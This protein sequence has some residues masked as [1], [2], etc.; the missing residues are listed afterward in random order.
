MADF[1]AQNHWLVDRGDG[2]PSVNL[3]VLSFVNPLKLLNLTTDAGNTQGI[4]NGMTADVVNYFKSRNI[5]VMLAVGGITYT[6]D[7][8]T[9]LGNPAQLATNAAQ[10]AASLGVGI[11]ID[12]EENTTPNLDAL[13]T[14]ISTYR[15]RQPYDASGA[16]PAARL[17]IDLGAGDRYLIGIA[18]RATSDWLNPANPVLDYANAMVPNRQPSGASDAIT[19]WQEHVDGKP[20]YSPPIGPLAPAKFTGA[21]YLETGRKAI[22]ECN[23]F[24]G[25]LESST[26]SYVQTVAPNGAGVTAGM[27]GY[28]FW[29]SECPSTTRVCTTPPNACQGGV[30]AGAA[31]YGIS[32]P[33]PPL[34]Q[35]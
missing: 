24:G 33:M 7:W 32:F 31:A 2:H 27:L 17:T 26:G 8:N 22:P 34:R 16:N 19:N 4:P 28:M 12:Y 35:N 14:F 5:R 13:A 21:L 10:V 1:D 11:E 18:Q 29:A 3:V 6:A 30:G 23:S 9:A 20:R 15:A 25:S